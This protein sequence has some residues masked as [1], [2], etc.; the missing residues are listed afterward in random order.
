M[1]A[2]IP[3]NPMAEV[4]LEPTHCIVNASDG[5]N[6]RLSPNPLNERNIVG[7]L[8]ND[9]AIHE[10]SSIRD[11]SNITVLNDDP[12]LRNVYIKNDFI[13]KISDTLTCK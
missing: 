1:V 13:A 11:W 9:Q 6:V 4:T 2:A 7:R 3:N 8:Q 5:V 10:I 12:S